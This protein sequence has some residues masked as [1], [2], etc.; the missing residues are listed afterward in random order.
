MQYWREP[1]MNYQ[2]YNTAYFTKQCNNFL[3]NKNQVSSAWLMKYTSENF[4]LLWFHIIVKIVIQL[5]G[6]YWR[7]AFSVVGLF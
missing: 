6:S 5:F 7:Q 1:G 3:W 4:G 2:N